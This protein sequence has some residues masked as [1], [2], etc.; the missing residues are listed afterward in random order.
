MSNLACSN[1][2]GR[3]SDGNR[4]PPPPA[5]HIVGAAVDWSGSMVS[6]EGAPPHQIMEQMKQLSATAK[7]FNVPTFFTLVAF[8]NRIE[9]PINQLNLLT[10]KLPTLSFLQKHLAPRGMTK[11]YD[12]GI[13]TINMINDQRRTYVANLSKTAAALKPDIKTSYILLTDGEDN[14]SGFNGQERHCNALSEMRKQNGT[15]AIFLGANIDASKTGGDLGFSKHTSIQMPP[16]FEGATQCLRAVSHTLRRA[17]TGSN[18]CSID[19]E[20][21]EDPPVN[22]SQPPQFLTQAVLLRQ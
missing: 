14:S 3:D 2:V 6:M 5:A 22:F 10:D 13:T 4:L 12:S 15:M 11:L 17:T 16:T 19:I 8:D 7:E 1:H 20:P 18:D 9:V 21:V